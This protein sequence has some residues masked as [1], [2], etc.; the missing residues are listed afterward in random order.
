[1]WSSVDTRMSSPIDYPLTCTY[2]TAEEQDAA[3]VVTNNLNSKI[4]AAVEYIQNNVD[5]RFEYLDI[6]TLDSP[7]KDRQLCWPDTYFIGVI[8]S[9]VERYTFHPNKEGQAAF[10]ESFRRHLLHQ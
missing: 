9:N 3:F 4:K 1:M 2:A 7:F 10:A 8:N 6:N 5:D